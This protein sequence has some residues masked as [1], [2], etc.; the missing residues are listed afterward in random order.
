M[1]HFGIR[2][3]LQDLVIL[4]QRRR[5]DWMSKLT[6]NLQNNI[7]VRHPDPHRFSF[8]LN[9][10]GY[11]ITGIQDKGVWAGQVRLHQLKGIVIHLPGKIGKVA[12]IGTYK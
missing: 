6:H 12:Q 7:I 9:G 8:L 3:I 1:D 11:H 10:P 4:L 5:Q 2:G